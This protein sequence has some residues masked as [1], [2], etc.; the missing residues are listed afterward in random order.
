MKAKLPP[1][2]ELFPHSELRSYQTQF[3]RFIEKNPRVLIQAPVGFGKTLMSLISTIPL[4]QKT[5]P[6]KPQFQLWIFVRTKAQIFQV[7]LKE[8]SKI[9]NSKRYGYLTA[10]PLII[11]SDLCLQMNNI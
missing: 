7:F 1:S 5:D 8:I 11:K 4:V 6:E 3:L 2:L 9:A 10:V